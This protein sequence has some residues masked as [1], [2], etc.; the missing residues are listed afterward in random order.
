MIQLPLLFADTCIHSFFGLRPW[1]YYLK[2]T[3]P[4]SCDIVSFKLLPPNSDVPLVLLA[5]IDDLLRIAAMVAIA[6][7]IV[8]AAGFIGSDGNPDKAHKARETVIN[9]LIGLAIAVV[10]ISFVSFIGHRLG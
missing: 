2:L 7:V 1:Y 9:S 8:G 6:Y 5:I 3:G 10:A 4:P